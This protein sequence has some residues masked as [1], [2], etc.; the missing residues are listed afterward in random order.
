M[1]TIIILGKPPLLIMKRSKALAVLLLLEKAK[2]ST[3]GAHHL[4][5]KA[6]VSIFGAPRLQDILIVRVRGALLLR[7][8]IV[9]RALGAHLIHD[10]R[11]RVLG[12][13]LPQDMVIV[14]RGVQQLKT[15]TLIRPLKSPR[16][17]E[18]GVSSRRNRLGIPTPQSTAIRRYRSFPIRTPRHLGLRV[19]QSCHLA[20]LLGAG[21]TPSPP[22]IWRK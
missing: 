15:Q 9:K 22:R 20:R 12:E 11:V 13:P 1:K 2:A 21:L 7:A 16:V 3:F 6:I 19:S 10:M 8:K 17:V 18:A 14:R 5:E 4:Q